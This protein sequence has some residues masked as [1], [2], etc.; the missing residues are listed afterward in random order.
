MEN[1]ME[2]HLGLFRAIAVADL[3]RGIDEEMGGWKH[4]VHDLIRKA[5]DEI[6]KIEVSYL[7]ETLTKMAQI[8]NEGCVV[9]EELGAY[10]DT[11]LEQFRDV[12]RELSE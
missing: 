2:N 4:P 10:E 6:N 12:L 3:L 7:E 5:M 9:E 8:K 11:L 1:T